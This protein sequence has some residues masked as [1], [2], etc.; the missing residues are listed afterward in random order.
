MVVAVSG[1]IFK[2]PD[3]CACCG[4][5]AETKMLVKAC[6]EKGT[7]VIRKEIHSYEFPYCKACVEH[8]EAASLAERTAIYIAGIALF[9][10]G[11]FY[12]FST[13]PDFAVVV[14]ISGAAGGVV[15]LVG[16]RARA[17]SFCVPNC[18]SLDR[19]VGYVDWDGS[20]QKFEIASVS[21]HD[22]FIMD[23][24]EKWCNRSNKIEER[25]QANFYIRPPCK[26]QSIESS[27]K[28]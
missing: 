6:K 12:F 21:Y 8:V 2:N 19:A 1:R 16:L 11:Y 14:I 15:S 26:P 20:V 3:I 28:R 7:R 25:L 24:A 17:R 18:V 5:H 10:A 13:A 22:F 23:N 9:A 4:G 27:T